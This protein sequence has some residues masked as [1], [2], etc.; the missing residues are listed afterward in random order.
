MQAFTS[1]YSTAN[2]IGCIKQLRQMINSNHPQAKRLTN[3]LLKTTAIMSQISA[4][5]GYQQYQHPRM[6]AMA[7]AK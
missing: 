6:T 5:V 4:G 1:E 2:A 3:H 7:V